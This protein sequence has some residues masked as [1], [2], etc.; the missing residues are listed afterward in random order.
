M[1][2]ARFVADGIRVGMTKSPK[3]RGTVGKLDAKDGPM[4]VNVVKTAQ[5]ISDADNDKRVEAFAQLTSEQ[6]AVVVARLLNAALLTGVE[7]LPTASQTVEILLSQLLSDVVKSDPG[8]LMETAIHYVFRQENWD[9]DVER[10]ER[11]DGTRF[12]VVNRF[13]PKLPYSIFLTTRGKTP[14]FWLMQDNRIIQGSHAYKIPIQAATALRHELS[15][16]IKMHDVG[17]LVKKAG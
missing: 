5:E 11:S 13:G 14:A 9:L 12:N 10:E 8:I 15:D 7:D 2:R 1:A 17:G 16:Y 4:V 3:G 6:F